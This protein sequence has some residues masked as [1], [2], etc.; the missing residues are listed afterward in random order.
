VTVPG[1]LRGG[2]VHS[3]AIGLAI[4]V[5][6]SATHPRATPGNP[7]QTPDGR[8]AS[9]HQVRFV[10]VEP[11]VRLEVLDW[12][13]SGRPVLFVGCYLTAHVYDNIAPKLTDGFQ[14]YAVTRRGVGASDQ[15][16]TGYSPQRR[17]DDV[18]AVIDALKLHK[19]IFVGNSCGGD[20]LHT[21]GARNPDRIGGLMYLDAAEDPTLTPADYGLPPFDTS[22]LPARGGSPQAPVEFPDADIRARERWPTDP[23]VRRAIVEDN[24]VKPDYAG[25]RVPVVAIYRSISKASAFK[26]YPPKTDAERQGVEEGYAHARGMLLKWQRDLLAG[27]PAAKIVELD[28]AN[29]YM[30][31]SNEADVIR[32]LRAFA[33]S[34]PPE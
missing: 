30:F 11:T 7:P 14:V 4:V 1:V 21:L 22:R 16:T 2:A 31:L 10:P 26:L 8:D 32:E 9:P 3:G 12:G 33:A 23:A 18:L 28:G 15:P 6:F 27:V 25:I 29:L 20:I 5:A 34:L 19:P 13:G 17:A 24:R